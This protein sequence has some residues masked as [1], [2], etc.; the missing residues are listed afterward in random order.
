MTTHRPDPGRTPTETSS[1]ETA[2]AYAAAGLPV[3][4]VHTI[5]SDGRCSCGRD[6][7]QRPGKHPRT[8]RGFKEASTDKDQIDA[9]WQRWPDA[10]V[11]IATGE[12][13]LVVI[14]VDVKSGAMG[15]A[16]WQAL[17]EELG[18][19]L[20][21]TAMVRTPSGGLHAYFRTGGREVA[22][23][24]STLAP[25][26]DVRARG[27]YVIAP[28]SRRLDAGYVWLPDH[29][30]ER[31]RELP[32]ALADLL[33]APPSPGQPAPAAQAISSGVRNATLTSLA[34]SM[35]RRG[36]DE[37]AI[38]A[39][40]QVVNTNRCD[41]PLPEAEVR[42][43]AAS[44]ASY[45]P[46]PP[47]ENLTDTGN[48]H[49]LIR[50]SGERIRYCAVEKAWYVHDGRR[51][52]RDEVLLIEDLVK[53]AHRTIY[54]EA[55]RCN[56]H[57]VRK[58]IVKW[59]TRSESRASRRATVECARS[60]PRIAIHP[61]QFDV[62][63]WL[64]NCPNGTLDLQ[65]GIIREHDPKDLITRLTGADYD[66]D[67]RSDLWERFLTEATGGDGQLRAWLQR[68][69][70]YSC[71]G[72]YRDEVYFVLVGDTS[73]GKTTFTEA[74]MR[75][76]GSYSVSVN[77]EAFLA[78]SNVGGTRDSIMPLK[79]K[80]LAVC[81]EFDRGRRFDE[82]LIKQ[83]VGGDTVTGRRIY[84]H[85]HSFTSTA[86]LWLHTNHVP[87]LSDDDE[88]TW[89]RI[90][91]VPFRCQPAV[92]DPQ[93]KATLCNADASGAAILAWMVE[94][95]TAWQRDGLGK[96]DAVVR[97]SRAVRL[98]MDRMGDFFDD[99]CV[100]EAGAWMAT[101][102]LQTAYARYVQATN[103]PREQQV[104]A[105]KETAGYLKRRGCVSET[106]YSVRGWSG[107]RFIDDPPQAQLFPT[108]EL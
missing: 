32:E 55:A 23:S 31:L 42:S 18:P 14:D 26:I 94:G 82:P 58:A 71:T 77:Q 57:D 54:E 104:S 16:N 89:R 6:D 15:L 75:A 93:V 56:D 64:L 98:E 44:I 107:I 73:T 49:R 67:A 88:A 102:D 12:A 47:F 1:A 35:R 95:C 50:I 36:M 34:G 24:A 52:R 48:A 65:T 99:V 19:E 39:A 70:G 8:A 11:A 38:F 2:R 4:P 68:G 76:L 85:E 63:G 101:R 41:P 33:A 103:V 10:G 59:A 46:A 30:L 80:R 100:F 43:I 13:G 83:L 78:R 3:F 60:E 96:A 72:D 21:D 61:E 5:R 84:E 25:S 86:K 87:R 28:P 105:G 20:E 29:G 45:D 40:L 51:W 53:E 37:D 97:E 27:G 69:A 62:H 90:R 92:S 81:S 108:E 74:L 17:V 79:G 9:W 91:I 106:R 66:P 7:C 22:T